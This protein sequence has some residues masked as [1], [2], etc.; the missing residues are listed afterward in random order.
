MTWYVGPWKKDDEGTWVGPDSMSQ[1]ID[2]RTLDQQTDAG[3]GLFECTGDVD[4]D[5]REV[6]D[7]LDDTL[8]PRASRLVL[9]KR[10][11]PR[12]NTLRQQVLSLVTSDS[13]PEGITGLK[14]VQLTSRNFG[15]AK[16]LG[17][18]MKV[19]GRKTV[20]MQ[21]HYE[22]LLRLA[23][24]D[25]VKTLD[26]DEQLGRK[27][28]GYELRK[29]G[30]SIDGDDWKEI[31]KDP[32][33]RQRVGR[34]AKPE[35][36]LS[37]DFNRSDE[38]PI[39]SPWVQ[40]YGTGQ[41]DLKNNGVLKTASSASNIVY[42]SALSGSDQDVQVDQIDD[43]NAGP[44]ARCESTS[45]AT[46]YFGYLLFTSAIRIYKVVT[47]S[48]TS[49]ASSTASSRNGTWL[50]TVDGSSQE[51]FRNTV[52]IVSASDTGIS[53]GLYAGIG[54]FS[55]AIVP[56]NDDWSAEDI[57]GGG[58]ISYTQLETSTRGVERGI[59]HRTPR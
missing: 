27:Q 28:L 10:Q 18:K 24:K 51:L 5:Y 30:M 4:R 8:S 42:N 44:A 14:P 2:L 57:G 45:V 31:I 43:K 58:G 50:L 11:R 15:E 32:Q 6:A 54:G 55:L 26:S 49:L 3:M 52:S 9:V 35:T 41:W 22:R 25:V 7:N 48:L 39:S 12:G 56:M 33:K 34:P 17:S 1:A 36:S 16:F 29:L 13:D 37:D 59:F 38:T 19:R 53:S 47:G 23:E 40:V 21:K 20:S 46:Y